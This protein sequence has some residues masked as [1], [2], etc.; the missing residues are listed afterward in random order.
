M[1]YEVMHMEARK[2]IALIAHDN[3][4]TAWRYRRIGT[5]SAAIRSPPHDQDTS[6]TSTLP[7]GRVQYHARSTVTDS[8][9]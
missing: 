3:R 8:T 2:R 4:K 5:F 1:P 6:R 7:S 9:G